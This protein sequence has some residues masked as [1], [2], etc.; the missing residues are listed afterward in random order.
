MI[1]KTISHYKILEHLGRGG[2]G[3]VYKAVTPNS[4]ALSPSSFCPRNSVKINKKSSVSYVKRRL[5]P[6][7]QALLEKMGFPKC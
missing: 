2:M 4:T 7:F 5:P 6:R 3:V 1:G